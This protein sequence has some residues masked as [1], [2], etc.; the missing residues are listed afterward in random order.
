MY[1]ETEE[2]AAGPASVIL[3]TSSILYPIVGWLVDARP[4]ILRSLFLAVPALIA[5]T[6]II[7]LFLTS[8]V[9]YWL[10]CLPS[11][12]GIGAAPLLLVIVVPRLVERR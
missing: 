2:R 5:S 6:Y 3:F 10:S 8:L 12:I 9:P 7:F 11:A 1:D 4:Q